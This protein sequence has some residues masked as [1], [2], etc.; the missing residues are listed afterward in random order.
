MTYTI[1]KAVKGINM[2]QIHNLVLEMNFK[3]LPSSNEIAGMI[4]KNHKSCLKWNNYI[5]ACSPTCLWN[6]PLFV[7]F[8][9][10]NIIIRIYC[11]KKNKTLRKL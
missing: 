9:F 11:G 10:F 1:K 4:Y 8:F 5:L 3:F 6:T 7:I 2:I